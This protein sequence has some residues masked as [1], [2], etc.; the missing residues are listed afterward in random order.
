MHNI[1]EVC[2]ALLKRVKL[3]QLRSLRCNQWE[4]I[5]TACCQRNIV[6]VHENH[7]GVRD[8]I[9]GMCCMYSVEN[10]ETPTEDAGGLVSIICCTVCPYLISVCYAY[11]LK[12]YIT[13]LYIDS[14]ANISNI[15]V[16]FM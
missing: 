14:A 3:K 10:S 6:L 4:D 5:R 12:H 15:S 7:N 1:G 8:N 11:N 9:K 13:L 16:V 2:V